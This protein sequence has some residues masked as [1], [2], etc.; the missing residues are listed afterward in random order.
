MPGEVVNSL[1]YIAIYTD[2]SVT[3]DRSVLGST[4][5]HCG[6]MTREDIGTNNAINFKLTGD[7]ETVICVVQWLVSKVDTKMTH[8]SILTACLKLSKKN[9]ESEM[10]DTVMYRFFTEN[11]CIS[12]VLI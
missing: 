7:F 2:G 8:A 6:K 11:D 5:K 1:H 10:G 12:L 3:K 4:V 9:V